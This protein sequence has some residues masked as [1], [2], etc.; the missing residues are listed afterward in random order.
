MTQQKIGRYEIRDELGAGGMGTVYLAHD[1][2]LRRDVALK[3]LQ[4]QLF[5]QDPDFSLR[6]ERE[7]TTIASLEHSSI[8]P[9]HDFGEDGEWLYFVMRLMNG[10]TLEDRIAQG[11][12]ALDEMTRI[13][14]RIASALDKA[15]SRGIV[16]R[17]LKPGNILFDDDGDA[18]LA[19]FGIVKTEDSTGIKTRTGLALGT[20]Q[21]MSPEQLEGRTLD[22]RSDIYSLGIVLYEMLSGSKP[23]D[24][25]SA[26]QV[27]V[28]HLRDPAPSLVEANPDLPP[29]LDDVIQKSMAKEPQLRYAT[30]SEMMQAVQVAALQEKAAAPVHDILAAAPPQKQ[31]LTGQE[32]LPEKPSSVDLQEALQQAAALETASPEEVSVTD[33]PSKSPVT[34][35]PQTVN[36]SATTINDNASLTSPPKDSKG[37]ISLLTSIRH[38]S[39]TRVIV[40]LVPRILGLPVW[41]FGRSNWGRVRRSD[42]LLIGS[43]LFALGDDH[44]YVPSLA[45]GV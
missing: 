33:L 36:Q 4:P 26:A 32:S 12:I 31:P 17:D 22:G 27:I 28:M 16:H 20:P 45:S 14:R 15:H 29:G 38:W 25:E 5:L 7:V 1:P 37:E 40:A 9:L 42:L 41:F 30:A 3:V 11:P 6:F 19:D 24:H 18:Y 39:K 43:G 21:Y 35:A 23:F 10:G 8:V 34:A 44:V 13:L 2:K